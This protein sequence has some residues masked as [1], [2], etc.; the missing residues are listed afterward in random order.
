MI[1][2]S[3]MICI[4]SKKKIGWSQSTS[5]GWYAARSKLALATIV[6]NDGEWYDESS[7]A[8]KL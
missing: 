6:A 2:I 3:I 4:D 5:H 8:T 7:L 1:L